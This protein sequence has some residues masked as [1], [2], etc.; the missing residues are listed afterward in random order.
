MACAGAYE[1]TPPLTVDFR[2]LVLD[3]M[4]W[5][6]TGSF[7]PVPQGDTAR[8][9][10]RRTVPNDSLGVSL[11]AAT[12]PIRAKIRPAP[13]APRE[14]DSCALYAHGGETAPQIRRIEGVAIS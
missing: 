10:L 9:L 4:G 3:R 12:Q 1:T 2:P 6:G 8:S 13:R 7:Q 14:A 5:L 11:R